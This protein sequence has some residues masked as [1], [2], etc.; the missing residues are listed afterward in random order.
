MAL[1]IRH[2][3]CSSRSKISSSYRYKKSACGI[4]TC[5]TQCEVSNNKYECK[6]CTQCAFDFVFAFG[7]G[8]LWSGSVNRR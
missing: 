8:F 5:L 6:L 1:F 2:I 4:S 3:E 7:F